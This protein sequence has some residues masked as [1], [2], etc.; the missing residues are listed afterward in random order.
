MIPERVKESPCAVAGDPEYSTQDAARICGVSKRQLQWLDERGLVSPRQVAGR[1]T[2]QVEELLAVMLIQQLRRKGASLLKLGQVAAFLRRGMGRQLTD[3]IESRSTVYL[4][5]DG[6]AC[7]L[8]DSRSRVVDTM[9]SS[10]HSMMLVCASAAA[11][12]LLEAI[13]STDPTIDA[14]QAPGGEPR[15]YKCVG[16]ARRSNAA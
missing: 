14:S 12:S 15:S 10:R 13:Q 16:Q 11:S 3:V 2:Y 6:I 8:T 5:T 7:Y 1:R 4:L 9:L